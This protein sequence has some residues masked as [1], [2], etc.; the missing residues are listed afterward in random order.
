MIDE[1]T[2]RIRNCAEPRWQH[3][4][5]NH[6]RKNH[7]RRNWDRSTSK[8]AGNQPRRNHERVNHVRRNNPW[9]KNHAV[10]T[11]KKNAREHVLQ[12]LEKVLEPVKRGDMSEL[13]VLVAFEEID[14]DGTGTLSKDNLA[15]WAKENGGGPFGIPNY[16]NELM[17]HAGTDDVLEYPQLVAFIFPDGPPVDAKV[18]LRDAV[19]DLTGD[20][21]KREDLPKDEMLTVARTLF[22]ALDI[23]KEQCV[24]CQDLEEAGIHFAMARMFID[25]AMVE[26]DDDGKGID[27]PEFLTFLF[28]EALG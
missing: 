13:D 12:M 5:Y 6:V 26:R 19:F 2:G 3:H 22:E 11:E 7:E 10:E 8:R 17:K 9:R 23:D 18:Q 21:R 20:T 14:G 27:F 15:A 4:R 28:P 16:R 25:D 1:T 24:S